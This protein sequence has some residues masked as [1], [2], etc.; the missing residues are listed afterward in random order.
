MDILQLRVGQDSENEDSDPLD[1]KAKV[2]L[3]PA[4]PNTTASDCY[5]REELNRHSDPAPDLNLSNPDSV[6]LSPTE[7]E[8]KVA[9]TLPRNFPKRQV[10]H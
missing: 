7:T 1:S 3:H 2:S 6:P 5:V 9:S 8:D 4:T 10:L